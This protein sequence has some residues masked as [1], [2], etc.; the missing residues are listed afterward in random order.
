MLVIGGGVI[1]LEMGSVYNRLGTQVEVIEFADRLLANFDHEVSN[2]FA[3]ILKKHGIHLHLSHKVVGGSKTN[4]GVQLTIED[5]KVSFN[6]IR[7]QGKNL[8][9]LVILYLSV[10]EGDLLHKV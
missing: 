9:F 10:Q 2:L 6:L 8:R 7:M 5:V 3:K 1:G 4:D